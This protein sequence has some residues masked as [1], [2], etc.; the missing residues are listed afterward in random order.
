METGGWAALTEGTDFL[1]QEED[2]E[3]TGSG[4]W[5]L[6]PTG[7]SKLEAALP[8]SPALGCHQET[9]VLKG[10]SSEHLPGT[11]CIWV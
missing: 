5:N 4:H 10:T 1:F 11:L 6:E 9:G 3:V 8:S 7:Y 2:L